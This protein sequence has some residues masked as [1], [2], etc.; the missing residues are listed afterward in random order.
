MTYQ[1]RHNKLLAK[2]QQK[3]P[4]TILEISRKK[5]CCSWSFMHSLRL[6]A[7]KG[8]FIPDHFEN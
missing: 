2:K 5:S 4:L 6:L 7:S 8:F 1:H 3:E